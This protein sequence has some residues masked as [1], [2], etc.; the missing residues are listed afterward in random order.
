MSKIDQM[1]KTWNSPKVWEQLMGGDCVEYEDL[2]GTGEKFVRAMVERFDKYGKSDL[3][4]S[5][6]LEIGCGTGRFLKPL[7]KR[8]TRVI[9][10]DLAQVLLKSASKYCAG[11]A[12]VEYRLNNGTDLRAFDSGSLDYVFSM[13]VF[14]HITD[15]DVIASYIK[16][17]LRVLKKDGLFFFCFIGIHV[18]EVG[19]GTTGAQITAEKLDKAL[20]DTEYTIREIS[21][22]SLNPRQ[23]TMVIVLQKAKTASPMLFSQVPIVDVPFASVAYGEE[24]DIKVK[25]LT[26]YDE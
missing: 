13:G 1:K 5:T 18:K 3:S 19:S 4:S 9:G 2:A 20:K 24:K 26:F 21:S 22:D 8:F 6:I 16:E 17:A 23:Q 11:L 14:Q 10:V 15:F 7:S 12:N 25:R